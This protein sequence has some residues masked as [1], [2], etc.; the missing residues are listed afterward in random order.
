MHYKH[1]LITYTYPVK[2][3]FNSLFTLPSALFRHQHYLIDNFSFLNVVL[4]QR[5]LSREINK[6]SNVKSLVVLEINVSSNRA[7]GVLAVSVN[8][9]LI[10][11]YSGDLFWP[12]KSIRILIPR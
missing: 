12:Q 3:L 11:M 9:R 10:N 8:V 2:I 6:K 4:G 5:S 7:D 1:L